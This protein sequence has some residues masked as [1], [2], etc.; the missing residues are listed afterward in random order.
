MSM[1]PEDPRDP[2]S[3]DSKTPMEP[4]ILEP[5]VPLQHAPM[6]L[7]VS[8]S[9]LCLV[10]SVFEAMLS[11][12]MSE[13]VAFRAPDSPR[14]FPLMLPDDDGPLFRIFASAVHHRADAAPYLPSTA[15]LLALA[16][17]VDKYN[18]MTALM[19]YAVLWLQRAAEKAAEEED[20]HREFERKCGLLLFA[21]ALDLPMQFAQ[22][23]W[24]VLLMH[25]GALID[26]TDVRGLRLPIPADHELLRHDLHGE[27]ARRK[28]RLRR[29]V[30]AALMEPVNRVTSML[31]TNLQF[32]LRGRNRTCPK[33]ATAIGNYMAMLDV[34]NLSPWRPQYETDSFAAIIKRATSLIKEWGSTTYFDVCTQMC[35]CDNEGYKGSVDVSKEMAIRIKAAGEWKL[36]A[37][38]DCLKKKGEDKANC[39][40]KHW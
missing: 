14:P 37:C 26:E 31:D 39:R 34:L 24:D 10:S 21:Y 11:G 13:G 40:L 35:I 1:S 28:S 36:W 27:L 9:I 38:L 29:E 25:R 18:C 19:P 4:S 17:L 2:D 20:E 16:A 23:S 22:L 3:E 30:H 32:E 33:A 12:N 6:Q 5:Y 7:R 15:T 8:S